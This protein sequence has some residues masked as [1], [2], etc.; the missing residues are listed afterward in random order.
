M[1]D[2]QPRLQTGRKVR[3]F[4]KTRN[5]LQTQSKPKAGLN[6]TWRSRAKESPSQKIHNAKKPEKASAASLKQAK[7]Q[8]TN[9]RER[10]NTRHPLWWR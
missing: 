9:T 5:F 3:L 4:F 1:A 8:D 6:P 7:P 10:P 2:N